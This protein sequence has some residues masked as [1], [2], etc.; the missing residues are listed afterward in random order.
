MILSKLILGNGLSFRSHDS[1]L[2]PNR[3]MPQDVLACV[4]ALRGLTTEF[5]T[6][7]SPLF[8]LFTLWLLFCKVPLLKCMSL[9]NRG[10]AGA[11]PT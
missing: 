11:S 5:L 1:L 4:H 7:Q 3:Q 8:F 10:T 9:G 6:H 2:M